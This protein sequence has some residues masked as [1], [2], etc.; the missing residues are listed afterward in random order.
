MSRAPPPAPRGHAATATPLPARLT[1]PPPRPRPLRRHCHRLRRACSAPYWSRRVAAPATERG[2]LRSRQRRRGG[3]SPRSRPS[4]ERVSLRLTSVFGDRGPTVTSEPA[5]RRSRGGP[6]G[7]PRRWAVGLSREQQEGERTPPPGSLGPPG[8]RGAERPRG[9]AAG[10]SGGAFPRPVPAS[11]GRS[12]AEQRAAGDPSRHRELAW[13]S[14]TRPPPMM[15]RTLS[16]P[17]PRGD[18]P[19][20]P[21]TLGGTRSLGDTLQ[22]GDTHSLGD[23]LQQGGTHSQGWP[24]PPCLF[25]LVMMALVMVPPSNQPTGTTGRSGILSSASSPVRS[26]VQRNVAIY[27]ASYAVFL[28][29]YLMLACC[30]GPRRRFPWNIILLSI[31]TL[32]M[33]LMTGTIASMYRTNAVLIAILITAIVAIIVT[34]FCFQTKVDFTSCPGLFCVLGIVVMVT[35]IVTAIVLSFKYV[36]WLHMLYAAIGAIAFTLFLAYDTQLVLG[37]RKNTLSPE[38]YV[39]GALTIYTDI[40][41]IFTFMLQIVGRD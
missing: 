35:G 26:F 37:N 36:P 33:G 2:R 18:T 34:I 19:N 40:I 6:A 13:R 10:G 11:R 28:V 24:C 29:T 23:T 31:F 12:P 8:R 32:A 39:Y 14:P 4:S 5:G 38:E 21:T 1:S 20:P 25:D 41:Y 22:Q 17:R 15:T 27:Y 30:Q 7:A 9:G 16:I 3:D